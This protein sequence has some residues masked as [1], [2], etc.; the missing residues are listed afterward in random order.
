MKG[1]LFTLIPICAALMLTTTYAWGYNVAEGKAI[2]AS[3]TNA[4]NPA[5]IA[6]NGLFGNTQRWDSYNTSSDY[7]E[8][9]EVDLGAN[10]PINAVN[11]RF[12]ADNSTCWTP[13]S[14]YFYYMNTSGAWVFL[15]DGLSPVNASLNGISTNFQSFSQVTA[16][17]FGICIIKRSGYTAMEGVG[18]S[19]LEIYTSDDF[20]VRPKIEISDAAYALYTDIYYQISQQFKTINS[21]YRN[22]NVRLVFLPDKFTRYSCSP[23][24]QLQNDGWH[25]EDVVVNYNLYA[26]AETLG[27]YYNDGDTNW[28]NLLTIPPD[29]PFRNSI[30]MNFFW[31]NN[32]LFS[33]YGTDA[34]VHELGHARG[35]HDLYYNGD[36]TVGYP[37]LDIMKYPY[38]VEVFSTNT[39]DA[40]NYFADNKIHQVKSVRSKEMTRE[41]TVAEDT[42]ESFTFSG[43]RQYYRIQMDG[44]YSNFKVE[45]TKT[46]SP[47]ANF[48]LYVKYQLTPTLTNYTARA[49]SSGANE[50]INLNPVKGHYFIMVHCKSGT[51][52]WNIK[53]TVTP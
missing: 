27:S 53:F 45:L 32:G 37:G 7:Y 18:V 49:N 33:A 47:A 30:G 6:V 43:Q 25:N 35:V 22:N 24:Q 11:V 9:L 17:K 44:D 40:L 42:N 50:T 52:T 51:G 15:A 34:L 19:E 10:Y 36:S 3:H 26:E 16:R 1:R 20:V 48:D 38:G 21:R 12:Y 14:Y 28:D 13:A 23:W 4:S 46:S 29:W 41:G 31:Q 5:S 8:T 39:V 2:T